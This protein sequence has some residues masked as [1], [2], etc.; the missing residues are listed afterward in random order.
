MHF[1]LKNLLTVTLENATSVL[2]VLIHTH[3]YTHTHVY[4]C[5]YNIIDRGREGKSTEFYMK[6]NSVWFNRTEDTTRMRGEGG[7]L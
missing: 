7:M 1:S 6:L 4:T 5:I 3:T 2:I